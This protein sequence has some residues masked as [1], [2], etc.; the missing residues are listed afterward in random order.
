VGGR[1]EKGGV[2][3]DVGGALVVKKCNCQEGAGVQKTVKVLWGEGESVPPRGLRKN[4]R[5]GEGGLQATTG[6]ERKGFSAL[7]GDAGARFTWGFALN[8]GGET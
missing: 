8:G 3:S 1:R 5:S 6:K 4:D 2:L 7:G